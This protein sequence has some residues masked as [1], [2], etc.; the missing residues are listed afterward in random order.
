MN[1]PWGQQQLLA[2]MAKVIDEHRDR[3]AVREPDGTERT[4]A[5]LAVL[6]DQIRTRLG[7][8]NAESPTTEPVGLMLERS[9]AAYATMWAA[10][11]LGRP[12]V[13]LNTAYPATRLAEIID[14]A[15]I[16]QVVTSAKHVGR[17]GELGIHGGD[18]IE[19]EALG[20]EHVPT[21]DGTF[22]ATAAGTTAYVLFTSG[23][24]GRPKGVPI[25][26]DNLWS[27][28]DNMA[29]AIPYE[30]HDVCSQVCE[31]SFDFSVHE[32]YLALLSGSS[33]C[34]A[35]TIDL[36]NPAHYA[37]RHG[38]TV[39]I[40]VP[41]LVRVVMANRRDGDDPLDTIRLSIFN[42]EALTTGVAEGWR[43]VAPNTAIWN[44][45]GPTECTVAVTVQPWDGEHELTESDVVSI[46]TAFD[47]CF[48]AIDSG[49]VDGRPA[50]IRAEAAPDGVVGELLLSGPQR[51][52]GYLD[53]ALASPFVEA[54]G[55]TWYRTGDRVRW[56]DGRLFHL[57]RLD[58]QVKIGG[59]RIEL[60]EIEH[61][62]R[63]TLGND[64]VAVIAHP[65]VQPNELV[66]FTT[67]SPE[68][69]V[70]AETTGLAS[71]MV[72]KRTMTIE[73]LPLNPHGKLD[74]GAL[75]RLAD[76]ST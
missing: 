7:R 35:R 29:A 66:L 22:D 75:H 44:N 46:G 47:D 26:Y 9:G 41:S 69:P 37:Q 67:R 40:S 70:T 12:Y 23:S 76:P 56:H 11:A 2:R 14:Q 45:Y 50:I 4:Y 58:H 32:I 5:D 62:L 20:T 68:S 30:P 15:G 8:S 64:D 63:E 6:I 31:L 48:T 1:S 71:Y 52:D 72:P 59:H 21:A 55:V 10:I 57:G 16:R 49:A 74:R 65:H 42:G 19:V 25:S 43:T 27:F 60:L 61:R 73:D 28:V 36:F 18:L 3:V 13:P 53:P 39:W 17:A 34:P 24:T 33:L 54:D 38:V 51:F